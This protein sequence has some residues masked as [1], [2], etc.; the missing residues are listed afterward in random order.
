MPHRTGA[1]CDS[2]PS[3]PPPPPPSV[4]HLTFNHDRGLFAA[5]TTGG[6][7]VFRTDP[8]AEVKSRDVGSGIGIVEIIHGST[9]F[10]LVGGINSPRLD[11]KKLFVWDD[12]KRQFIGSL[13]FRSPVKSVRIRNDRLVAVTAHHVRVFNLGD[14]RLITTIETEENPRGLCEISQLGAMVVACLGLRKG[15]VRLAVLESKSDSV[16]PAHDSTIAAIG[17]THSGH[18][19]ATASSKGTVI[20][21]FKVADGSVIHEL[22][23]GSERAEIHTLC[24][25]PSAKWLAVSRFLPNYFSS[26]WSLAQFRVQ[27]GIK[28]VVAFGQQENTLIIVGADGRCYNMPP[29]CFHT[30]E[31][32]VSFTSLQ[33]LICS[34]CGID[35]T[36]TLITIPKDKNLKTTVMVHMTIMMK[37]LR[38]MKRLEVRSVVVIGS[39]PTLLVTFLSGKFM[40]LNIF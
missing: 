30:F 17:L 10:V 5:G 19:L 40:S 31:S 35:S 4:L 9:F 11:P 8:Y 12:E 38:M 14:F 22:R 13:S 36:R 21:I 16:V 34:I 32:D 3:P 18:T 23:R 26:D 7:K 37:R 33:E 29:V 20:R 27:E 1:V 25:S 28:H 24:F 39:H 15:H 6:F 2:T